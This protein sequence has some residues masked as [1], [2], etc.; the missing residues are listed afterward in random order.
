METFEA[1][2]LFDR[3]RLTG[4]YIFHKIAA[5]G[6]LTLLNRISPYVDEL[7]R[8]LLLKKTFAGEYCTHLAAKHD[9]ELAK[10]LLKKLV[11]LGADLNAKNDGTGN[12]VLHQKVI[13]RNY[14]MVSWLCQQ[15][16]IKLEICNNVGLTAY[17]IAYKLHDQELIKILKNAGAQETL[18][19]ETD[20]DDEWN[21]K[22]MSDSVTIDDM[23][24]NLEM[25]CELLNH[26]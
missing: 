9:M 1:M 3:D 8:S 23:L 24:L 15:P 7:K 12:T 22:I 26:E 2:G 25:K 10:R 5:A 11:E 17:A 14:Q 16:T 4:A 19:C 6:S 18:D 13:E 21:L 20:S